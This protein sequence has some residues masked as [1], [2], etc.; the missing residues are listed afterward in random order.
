MKESATYN[1]YIDIICINH[2]ITTKNKMLINLFTN[3]KNFSYIKMSGTEEER[4]LLERF[5]KNIVRF[6]DELI[7]MFPNEKD[8][9]LI[10]ILVK[11]QI[12]TTQ[13]MSYFEMVM[14]N[15]EIISSIESRNDTFILSNVLFSKIS[16]STVFKN[17]WEKHLDNDDKEMIWNWVDSFKIMTTDYMKLNNRL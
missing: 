4:K 12:P 8:F 10:R 7:E 2:K 16:N 11:D 13:I 1:F 17:L 14:M 6:F 9:I 3:L 5:Q 15:K